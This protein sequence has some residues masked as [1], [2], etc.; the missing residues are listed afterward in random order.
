MKKRILLIALLFT[1]IISML[2]TGC[3]LP[4]DTTASDRKTDNEM[5]QAAAPSGTYT[6]NLNDGVQEFLGIR[7][8]APVERWKAPNDVTTTSD[9][10]IDATKWGPCCMMPWDDVEISSQGELSEDCLNLNIWTK[11]VAAKGKP[12]IVF[13]H[14]QSEYGGSHD[15]LYYGDT[16]TRNLPKGDDVVYVTINYRNNIFRIDGSFFTEG[17]HG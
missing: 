2:A 7:Y 12:V 13:L 3:G 17:I 14:G 11:N 16:F 5:P 15:P 6:G 8:A 10:K 1:L 9:D 4:K